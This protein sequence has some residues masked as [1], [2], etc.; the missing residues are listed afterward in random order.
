MYS[1]STATEWDAALGAFK[2]QGGES[3]LAFGAAPLRVNASTVHADPRLSECVVGRVHC[4][5]SV[6]Q[7]LALHGVAVG[8]MLVLTATTQYAP[9]AL[10][11][12]A[13]MGVGELH[14]APFDN[15]TRMSEFWVTVLPRALS[16]SAAAHANP[17]LDNLVAANCT[18]TPGSTADIA[19]VVLPDARCTPS[20]K[21]EIKARVDAGARNGVKLYLPMITLPPRPGSPWAV[22]ELAMPG[23]LQLVTRE[24]RD[25][26]LRFRGEANGGISGLYQ[27]H[28]MVLSGTAFW[29]EQYA[30]YDRTARAVHAVDASLKVVLSPYWIVNKADPSNQSFESTIQGVAALSRID[31]DV[32]APQEGRG[33]GKCAVFTAAEATARISV[34]DPNLAR[35]PNV[36]SGATFTEQF[37]ASTTE[38]YAASRRAVDA[39]NKLRSSDRPVALWMNLEAFEATSINPCDSSTREDR[40]NGTRVRRSWQLVQETAHVDSLI[41][42][43]WDPFFTC[44]PVGY[45]ESLH[46]Q[47]LDRQAYLKTGPQ[48]DTAP[49][50]SEAQITHNPPH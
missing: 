28:E 12:C 6:T 34:V 27:S 46:Q 26:G 19:I 29:L 38:L 3:I 16:S 4:L 1:R 23:F 8:E 13:G 50:Y 33:T 22:D 47:L 21:D 15:A 20:P 5:D 11:P 37:W 9:A 40:T 2:A 14:L 43:M 32:V 42:F 45:T 35:Y 39:A 7:T 41:S 48:V 36:N 24:V 30:F 25:L 44:V 17:G 10:T 31:I 49:T 18:L